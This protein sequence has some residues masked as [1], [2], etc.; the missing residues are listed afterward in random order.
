MNAEALTRLRRKNNLRKWGEQNHPD[1]TGPNATRILYRNEAQRRVET[2]M[3][4]GTVTYFEILQEE[5][6]EAACEKNEARLIAELIDVAAV[7]QDWADSI[8]RRAQRRLEEAKPAAPKLPPGR[9]NKPA[10]QP[11]RTFA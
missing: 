1:G 3:K 11:G 4:N 6:A 9:D 5:F 10:P 7:A 2:G 8:M